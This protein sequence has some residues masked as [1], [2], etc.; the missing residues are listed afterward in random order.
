MDQGSNPCLLQW[1]RVVLTTEPP[2]KSPH[3]FLHRWDH[4]YGL[5]WTPNPAEVW[6]LSST[7]RANTP[8]AGVQMKGF[9]RRG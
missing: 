8:P 5:G 1:K 9:E 7:A 4:L 3:F 2:G 6:T